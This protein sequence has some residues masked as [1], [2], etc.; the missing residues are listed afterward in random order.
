VCFLWAI[1]ADYHFTRIRELN[2][3]QIY[4]D[5]TLL[6]K[7]IDQAQ[8]GNIPSEYYELA[9][10]K[11]IDCKTKEPYGYEK[12]KITPG[13]LKVYLEKIKDFN[14]SKTY[15]NHNSEGLDSRM[16]VKLGLVNWNGKKRAK[17]LEISKLNDVQYKKFIYTNRGLKNI[18]PPGMINNESFEKRKIKFI[19]KNL[20]EEYYK[21]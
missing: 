7:M 6:L 5:D 3:Q 17:G 15:K 16:M 1:G 12:L 20:M 21:L 2:K 13:K 9:I 11:I 19:A 8:C 10:K 18:V 4:F 14:E